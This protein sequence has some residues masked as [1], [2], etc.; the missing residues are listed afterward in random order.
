[1]AQTKTRVKLDYSG[2]NKLRKSDEMLEGINDLA[3][4]IVQK[5]RGGYEKR[6][7]YLSTR[8]TVTVYAES[9]A[10]KRRNAKNNELLKAVGSK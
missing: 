4:G 6:T 2:F 1:M 7:N 5:T 9:Y 10:A 8:N 3:D